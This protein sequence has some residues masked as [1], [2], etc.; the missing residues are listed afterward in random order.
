MFLTRA[1]LRD[2]FQLMMKKRTFIKKN[3][4][5]VRMSDRRARL[6][7]L[8]RGRK[9]LRRAGILKGPAT[10][11][12]K[13]SQKTASD[14]FDY[15]A[16]RILDFT[17]NIE[18]TLLY[19]DGLHASLRAKWRVRLVF[20]ELESISSEALT[21]LLGQIYLLQNK[22][23]RQNLSGCYP[24]SRKIEHLLNESGFFGLLRVR[25]RTVA[26]RKTGATRFLTYKT[27]N[28]LQSEDI[29]KI[30]DELFGD[31]FSVPQV[32][33]SEVYRALSEAMANVGEHAYINKSNIT[34][35]MRGRWWIGASMSLKKN[36][37]TLT[38]YDAG[39]GIPKTLPLRYNMELIRSVLSYLPGIVP[40]DDALIQAAIKIGRTR[41]HRENRGK[42][43][44][45]LH[46]LIDRVGEGHLRIISRRG[47]YKYGAAKSH[48]GV[49]NGFLEGTL[50][51]WELPLS[52]AAVQLSDIKLDDMELQDE[53]DISC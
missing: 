21:Y 34:K 27:G 8:E 13:R 30:R 38:F 19:F 45:D 6:R 40:N 10:K 39:V 12:R 51:S 24:K 29:P 20:E 35:E 3:A 37:F 36:I 44:M 52:K 33:R 18:N 11:H 48:G 50:I 5:E 32:V 42:G 9:K 4:V 41:T 49:M 47:W 46:R 17:A 15:P 31:D 43:L 22:Y 53:N 2:Y 28:R 14:W 1:R 26:G 23:G 25:R 16:P 7:L